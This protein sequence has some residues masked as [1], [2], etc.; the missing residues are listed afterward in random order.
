MALDFRT[1]TI[2]VPQT[3]GAYS[4][5]QSK[6]FNKK[7]KNAEVALKSFKLDYVGGYK[8]SDIVQVTASL[9]GTG[10]EDV[11]YSVKTNYSGGTYTGEVTVLI[12][13]D[14]EEYDGA[15]GR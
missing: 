1:E 9:Q 15:P 8:P 7:I 14:V 3:N 5:N 11:E 10:D 13:A 4:T 12:I 6:P 2:K